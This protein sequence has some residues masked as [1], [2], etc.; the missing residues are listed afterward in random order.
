MKKRVLSLLLALTMLI[1]MTPAAFAVGTSF[2]DVSDNAWYYNAVNWA[3]E[4]NITG[5]I[6]NGM[7]GPEQTCTRAQVVVFLWAAADKPDPQSTVSPFTDVK[8]SDWF[9]KAVMWA[10]ENN[11]TGGTS[12]TTFS[13]DAACT[14]AAVA[15]F[16]YAAQGKPGYA[17]A[18][19]TFTDVSTKDWFYAPVAWAVENNVT[20]GI[21]NG[22]F[23]PDQSCT[24]AQIA[25]FLWKADQIGND[26]IVTDP[27]V[28]TPPITPVPAL[29][30]KEQP[31]GKTIVYGE[32]ALL[33]VKAS[34]GMEPYS[35]QWRVDGAAI[36]GATEASYE[37][38]E[39]GSYS[40]VVTDANGT[41]VKSGSATVQVEMP[42]DGSVVIT[43]QPVGGEITGSYLSLSVTASGGKK[44]YSY[45]WYR[46]GSPI[47]G[48]TKAFCPATVAGSY[49]CIVTDSEN[50]SV[51]SHPAEVTMAGAEYQITYHIPGNDEYLQAQTIENPN[52]DSYSSAVGLKLKEPEVPGYIFEG[53]FDGAGSYA[54]LV[55]EIKV[56]TTGEMELYAKWSPVTYTITFHNPLE[57]TKPMSYTVN[58]GA[59]WKNPEW[60]RYIFT[61]WCDE[62]GNVVTELPKGTTGNITLYANWTSERNSTFPVKQLDDPI[63][64]EDD[65]SNQILFAYY[66]GRIENVP[67][68]VITDYGK[69]SAQ[70]LTWSETKE[71]SYQIEQSEATKVA[72]SISNATVNSS[73]WTLSEELSKHY[74]QSDEHSSEVTSEMAAASSVQHEATGKWSLSMGAGGSKTSSTETGQSF[75]L[76]AGLSTNLRVNTP[77]KNVKG[78]DNSSVGGSLGFEYENYSKNTE[79]KTRSWNTNTGFEIGN[80]VSTNKS[81]SAKIGKSIGEKHSFSQSY[82]STEEWSKSNE[83]ATTETEAREYSTTVTYSNAKTT[84]KSVTLDNKNA[85]D[86]YYRLV[87]AGTIHV[88]AVVGYDIATG[89]Y[90]TFT[91]NVQDATKEPVQYLDY[92]KNDPAYCDYE[93]GVLPFEVPLFVDEYINNKI[94]ATEGLTI[95][96]KTGKVTAYH[97]TG[98]YVIIPQ[99]QSLDNGDG[100]Y[101]VVEIT[102][103]EADVFAGNTKIKGVLLPESMTEIPAS[104][105]AGCTA[106]TEVR[107]GSITR[108]G[109]NA[110]KGCSALQNYTVSK[111]VEYMGVNAFTGVPEVAVYARNAAVAKAAFTGGA[112]RILVN[113]AD[114]TD[115]LSDYTINIGESTKTF[116]LQGAM[117]TYS[118]LQ[119]ISKAEETV[120]NGLTLKEC[121]GTPLEIHSA[122]LGL[123]RVTVESGGLAMQLYAD[124]VAISLYDEVKLSSRG[125][126]AMSCSSIS[127]S[128][129]DSNVHSKLILDGNMLVSGNV[130]GTGFV[131]FTKGKIIKF[132]TGTFTVTFDPNGGKVDETT[133]FVESGTAIGELPV[134]A[135]DYHSFEG[136][137]TD[138]NGGEQVTADTTWPAAIDLTLYAHWTENGVSEWVLASELPAGA[139]VTGEK[140]T[141]TLTTIT[142]SKETALEGYTAT[143]NTRWEQSGAG[144]KDYASFHKGFDKNHALYKEMAQSQPYANEETET[145]KREVSTKKAGYIYWHWMWK[146]DYSSS[147]TLA[148]SPYSGKWDIYGVKGKGRNYNMFYA[149]KS[150]VDCPYL[151]TGYCCSNNMK[152]YNCKEILPSNKSGVGTPRFFR[153]DYYT[154]SYIDYVKMFE[155][156]KVET[157][158]SKTQVTASDTISN[159]QKWVQYREK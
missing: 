126:N 53:W 86:G 27:P 146:T 33:T 150:T 157:L 52:P 149:L 90:Y 45:V 56:G 15:T 119:I 95:N 68:D 69:Q 155:Y 22:K 58:T 132:D 54:E 57:E 96:S 144:S 49:F 138:L 2:S 153:F 120:I 151:S 107:G 79:S 110:F 134:P 46:D 81:L 50:E 55:K 29:V 20:G 7:F 148:I 97:G 125:S 130:D 28:T 41:E 3:V 32:T 124:E 136:W 51:M 42:E 23:G 73:S 154:C 128:Q 59:T 24:R 158:E 114:M 21:G 35:Y 147:T 75:N 139:K 100:T 39:N 80:S 83:L 9:F 85:K 112:E 104:A 1:G 14:R 123:N 159:V 152:S 25:T 142:E 108:I 30:I 101:T 12:A 133:R 87:H 91:Y 92:S 47:L 98:E 93:N 17:S 71:E 88:F 60:Y 6:G 135:K 43:K 36:S 62:K 77:F 116:E 18:E 61:G 99:Y 113:L 131:S 4:N 11:I 105:F 66:I 13:P 145:T 48:E 37:A 156:K 106:L 115:T 118:G 31:V 111:N 129:S 78:D 72:E 8:E 137:Y 140:W 34:G 64:V 26:P 10:V 109:A 63:I 103:I 94:L 143:G 67:L 89:S 117:K 84:S 74:E 19:G 122:K 38:A 127:I 76:N 102:G 40:C 141:Y 82:G 70:G 16:L 44:P 5:G 65:E 121:E